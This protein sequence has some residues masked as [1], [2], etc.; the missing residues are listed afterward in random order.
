MKKGEFFKFL[1]SLV[2]VEF[3]S[4]SVAV[5]FVRLMDSSDEPDDPLVAIDFFSFSLSAGFLGLIDSSDESDEPPH[6]VMAGSFSLPLSPICGLECLCLDLKLPD[7]NKACDTKD[8][9][10]KVIVFLK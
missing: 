2:V 1:S 4:F 8:N 7:R 9:V 3:F 10:L 6:T 5:G